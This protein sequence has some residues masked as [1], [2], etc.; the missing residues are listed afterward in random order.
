M[1]IHFDPERVEH[2]IAVRHVQGRCIFCVFTVPSLVPG[3]LFAVRDESINF[4]LYRTTWRRRRSRRRHQSCRH[5]QRFSG[6]IDLQLDRVAKL[7]LVEQ[8]I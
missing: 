3:L 7:L 5:R 6:P 4:L 2:L 8:P 1:L